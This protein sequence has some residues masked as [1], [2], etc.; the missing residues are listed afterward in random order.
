MWQAPSRDDI[1]PPDQIDGEFEGSETDGPD[2]ASGRQHPLADPFS[3]LDQI[4]GEFEGSETDKL[5]TSGPFAVV[6]GKLSLKGSQRNLFEA[7]GLNDLVL[8][9]QDD[10]IR[11]ARI[12][13]P[14][15]PKKSAKI[16]EALA[17]EAAALVEFSCLN[18]SSDLNSR[19]RVPK[20]FL[21]VGRKPLATGEEGPCIITETNPSS[22]KETL[23]GWL[24]ER[25]SK[26]ADELMAKGIVSEDAVRKA[27]LNAEVE[28]RNI[29]WWQQ[30]LRLRWQLKLLI[31]SQLGVS[32]S[33]DSRGKEDLNPFLLVTQQ[34]ADAVSDFHS[35][36]H[37]A[38]A[39]ARTV[40]TQELMR[41]TN[42][43]NERALD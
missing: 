14:L 35:A 18:V 25:R 34:A 23:F 36:W 42:L 26:A 1:E 3:A 38:P 7:L 28:G 37:S 29:I 40:A 15:L 16:A 30:K 17:A 43:L 11:A 22:H 32:I 24:G 4:D 33:A 12:V 20:E 5:A 39:D 19:L 10:A 8:K 27:E 41:P 6:C 21:S 13:L 9:P 31:Y 2:V